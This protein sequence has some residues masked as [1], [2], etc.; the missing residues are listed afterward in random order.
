MLSLIVV[1]VATVFLLLA[2]IVDL[3]TGEIPE[4]Y[5][6]G[7]AA[8]ILAF[9]ITHSIVDWSTSYAVNAF[10]LG[11]GYLLIGYVI[12]VLGGWGG[13]DVKLMAGV[14]CTLGYLNSLGYTWQ[15]SNITPYYIT[16]LMDMGFLAVP[17]AV[18]YSMVLTASKPVVIG[19]F[20]QALGRRRIITFLAASFIP[21]IATYYLGFST[22]ALLYLVLPLFT[23]A[24]IYLK[25]VEHAA[26]RKTIKVSEL[27]E[28]DI[29]AEDVILGGKKIASSKC[30]EG[31]TK[32]QMD[33]IKKLSTE[34]KIP[35]KITIKWGVKFAPVILFSFLL[36]V[37]VGNLMEIIFLYLI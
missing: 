27:R 16:Y 35:G 37:T 6:L 25:T 3:K 21:T 20:K 26:L 24:T 8:I 5:S 12:Y 13:G 29:P 34:G 32:E 18:L 4:R 31:V 9:S 11:L 33:K 7:L 17:Y 36:T 10:V 22:L 15:F 1:L 30:I 23:L 19:E 28:G 14:G 2:S